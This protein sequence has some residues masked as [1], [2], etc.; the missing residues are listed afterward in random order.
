MATP[1]ATPSP[2]VTSSRRRQRSTRLTVAAA[3]LVLAAV[4]VLGAAV[5][6]SWLLGLLAGVLAVVL[7]AAATRITHAELMASRR[8]A[9]RD[10]AQQA[11]DYLELALARDAEHADVVSQLEARIEQR[12]TT[13][14]EMSEE[15]AAAQ[16][17]LVDER[18]SAKEQLAGAERAL[19]SERRRSASS[20]DAAEE[21]A[22]EA[23]AVVAELE[24]ELAELRAELD[25]LIAATSITPHRRA[26]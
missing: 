8:E 21:R 20:L 19:E 6:G 24:H 26:V 25:T 18:R 14:T 7:G 4:A 13:L 1:P 15:L 22:A 5:T 3:L 23:I 9:N 17:R 12:E 10:R 16:R 2:T 11:R